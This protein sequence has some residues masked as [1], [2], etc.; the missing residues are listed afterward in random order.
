M[1]QTAEGGIYAKILRGASCHDVA[2]LGMLLACATVGSSIARKSAVSV[3]RLLTAPT[4]WLYVMPPWMLRQTR[5]KLQ[6]ST[7]QA[8]CG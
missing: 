8:A 6:G 5:Q 7:V 4:A 1:F 2:I 3:I